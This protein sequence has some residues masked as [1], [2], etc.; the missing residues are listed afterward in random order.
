MTKIRRIFYHYQELEETKAG[1]WRRL[2][3]DERKKFVAQAADLMRCPEEFLTA[4][5]QAIQ[6][7]PKSCEAAFSA[8]AVNQIAF[9]GHCGCCI[10]TGSPE[11][12]NRVAA[13]ALNEWHK[14]R[15]P[16]G[17]KDLFSA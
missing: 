12:C 1:L 4:M 11:E 2:T 5:R 9:L 17:Q 13:I 16:S 6:D 14:E 15:N 7:W 8:D 10:A 3:G